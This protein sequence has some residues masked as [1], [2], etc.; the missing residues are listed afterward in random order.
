VA[1]LKSES[2]ENTKVNNRKMISEGG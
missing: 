1:T 2:E